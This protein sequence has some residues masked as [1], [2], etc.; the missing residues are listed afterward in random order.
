MSRISIGETESLQ[1]KCLYGTNILSD[2][3]VAKSRRDGPD[4]PSHL[5]LY[6]QY[7]GHKEFLA[8]M[9]YSKDFPFYRRKRECNTLSGVVCVIPVVIHQVIL[10]IGDGN[11]FI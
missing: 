6:K 7:V 5:F 2:Q 10:S 4:N 1:K 11:N 8:L 3:D 9:E